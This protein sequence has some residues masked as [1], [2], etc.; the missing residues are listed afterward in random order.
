MAAQGVENNQEK[1]KED[2]KIKLFVLD[3]VKV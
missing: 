3:T 1:E 2:D